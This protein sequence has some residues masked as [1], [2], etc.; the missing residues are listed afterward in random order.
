MPTYIP[1]S[2]Y[3]TYLYPISSLPHCITLPTCLCCKTSCHIPGFRANTDSKRDGRKER[4]QFD[5][6]TSRVARLCYNL[7]AE[8]VFAE[9]I[10]QK[11]R[12]AIRFVENARFG[13]H[14]RDSSTRLV[15]VDA[16][17]SLLESTKVSLR[18]SSTTWLQKQQPT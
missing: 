12:Q 4:V 15:D 6:I 13:A 7:D 9:A 11:V 16:F 3:P 5:K 10:T 17:R 1:Q 18:S 14:F 2:H 8:H